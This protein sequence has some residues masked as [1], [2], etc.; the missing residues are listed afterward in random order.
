MRCRILLMVFW[1]IWMASTLL[2]AYLFFRP[3]YS[4]LP[5]AKIV[6]MIIVVVLGF[7]WGLLALWAITLLIEPSSKLDSVLFAGYVSNFLFASALTYKCF[8]SHSR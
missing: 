1:I 5:E 3:E 8:R 4:L 6:P 2:A 7:P